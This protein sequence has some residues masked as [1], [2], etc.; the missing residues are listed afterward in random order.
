LPNRS[1]S[2]NLGVLTA[3]PIAWKPAGVEPIG[4]PI[5]NQG[6][7]PHVPS[8]IDLLAAGNEKTTGGPSEFRYIRI[9]EDVNRGF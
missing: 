1:P 8:V 7:N 2:R 3:L 9:I 6:S 5:G 4:S